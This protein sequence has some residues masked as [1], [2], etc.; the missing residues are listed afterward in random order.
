MRHAPM[1]RMRRAM[2]AGAVL[3]ALLSCPASA[4]GPAAFFKDKTIT[5]AVGSSTGGGLDTFGR[6]VSRH[7][8]RHIPGNPTVIVANMPGAGGNLAASH[9]YAVAPKDG[10][11]MAITFPGVII[12]PL[13]S[14]AARKDFDPT[15]FN[16]IGNANAE[17]LVCMIRQDA[18]VKTLEDLRSHEVILGATAIGSTTVDFPKIAKSVLGTK[19]RIVTGYKGAREVTIAAERAEV[20]GICGVGWSTIKVQYREV[21]GG[22]L[23][24]RMF[25][26][27][28]T[29]GHP[30]LSAAGVPLM[31]SLARNETERQ[32]LEV[33]YAQSAFSRP[34][35]L[36]PGVPADRLAAL[37][38]AFIETMKDP[39]LLAEAA[40]MNVDVNPSTGE[41]VQALV[42]KM[43]AS[44]PE[45]IARVKQALGREK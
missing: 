2:I 22:K 41:E 25:A 3:L 31:I 12:D 37:R 19:F 28:D 8:G 36:P 40:K 29:R 42:A 30:E 17:T 1:A 21:L 43:Y 10:T 16:Y 14:A 20:Q 7:L 24:A 11:H 4:Q 5:I 32:T 26:Q 18:P 44:P 38:T 23:F 45:I 33:F 39:V 13:L 27:E 15:K 9:L 6:L 35:I 34:F